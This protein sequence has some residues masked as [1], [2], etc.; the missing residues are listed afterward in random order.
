MARFSILPSNTYMAGTRTIPSTAV[1]VG[2]G[3]FTLY[4]DVTS[5]AVAGG[6]T[7]QISGFLEISLDGG[8]KWQLLVAL[9]DWF[10]GGVPG[11]RAGSPPY[12][13]SLGIGLPEP[14]NPNR[15]IR[16]EITL[17]DAILMNVA[18]EFVV[19]P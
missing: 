1:P 13:S 5:I 6:E 18:A 16:G 2:L 7:K 12:V 15:R 8:A 3:Y 17:S 11:P 9:G 4:V 10:V 14:L 19:Y